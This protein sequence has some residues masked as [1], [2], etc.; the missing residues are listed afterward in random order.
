M[1]NLQ[2]PV[3]GYNQRD[4]IWWQSYRC[5]H[6][7]HGYEASLRD[8]CSSDAGSSGSYAVQYGENVSKNALYMTDSYI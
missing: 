6:Y 4:V 3:D 2:N 7:H 1:F 8:A 5:Q